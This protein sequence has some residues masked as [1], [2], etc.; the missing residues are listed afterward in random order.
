MSADRNDS[1]LAKPL[2]MAWRMRGFANDALEICEIPRPT[3]GIGLCVNFAVR[4][5]K[6]AEP[7]LSI[8]SEMVRIAMSLLVHRECTKKYTSLQFAFSLRFSKCSHPRVIQGA[9]YF[10]E[11]E[12]LREIERNPELL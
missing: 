5:E 1:V 2:V 3:G 11:S 9:R 8:G 10:F 4:N 6:G 7:C 12:R